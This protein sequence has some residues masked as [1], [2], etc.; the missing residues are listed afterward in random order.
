[1]NKGILISIIALVVVLGVVFF[2]YNS[3]SDIS[4]SGNNNIESSSEDLMVDDKMEDKMED[5][6]ESV[7]IEGNYFEFTQKEYEKALSENKKIMLYFYA[8]WCPTC[9]A[10]QPSTIGAFSELNDENIVGFRVNYK[11]SDTDSYEENLA[12]EFGITYQHTKVLIVNGKEV[13]K[14]LETWS[15][16]RYIEELNK[17]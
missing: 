16:E 5:K 3:N 2:N 12:K 6:T 15:K 10:E 13:S 11:D 17:L 14:S 9:R 7:R 4:D 8:S 1:M